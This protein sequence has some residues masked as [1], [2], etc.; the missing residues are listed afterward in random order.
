MIERIWIYLLFPGLPLLVFYCLQRRKLG[1]RAHLKRPFHHFRRPAGYSQQEKV[2]E[3]WDTILELIAL[4]VLSAIMPALIYALSGN[5][6]SSAVVGTV[7]CPV[8]ICFLLKAWVPYQD[9]QLG[10]LGEQITGA[11][12]DSLQTNEIR[13]YH[14]LVFTKDGRRWNVDHVLLTVRGI[15]VIETKA[16]RKKNVG[17]KFPDGLTYD[18][19]QITFPNGERDR[20]ALQQVQRNAEDLQGLTRRWTGGETVPIF[21]VLVYPGWKVKRTASGGV[22]VVGHDKLGQLLPLQ[23]EM[24][25]PKTLAILKENLDRECRVVLEDAPI[26]VDAFSHHS[27]KKGRSRKSSK[28]EKS[29]TLKA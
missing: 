29:A 9:N 28:A 16:R 15:L 22:Y 21:P 27:E 8:A 25:Y 26:Q 24:I 7:S 14:D 2:A 20:Q 18:G 13:A 5:W 12:L 23:G 10:L 6:L 3:Q 17:G 11:E 19:R 4:F 1:K